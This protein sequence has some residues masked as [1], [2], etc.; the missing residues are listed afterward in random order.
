MS[1]AILRIN[2]SSL[3]V[4]PCP[5]G[6]KNVRQ[7]FR[8][9]LDDGALVGPET[10]LR[11]PALDGA[12]WLVGQGVS[13]DRLMTTRAAS[14]SVDSWK[15]APVGSFAK[16]AVYD[17]DSDVNGLRLAP[18]LPMAIKTVY[19][20]QATTAPARGVMPGEGEPAENGGAS[21]EGMAHGSAVG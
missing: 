20:K 17:P 4:P 7:R 13:P 3:P 2:Y 16:L 11:S 12:R 21:G 5:A 1:E 14:S 15:P 10:G 18:W 8:C 19:E 6:R 9:W